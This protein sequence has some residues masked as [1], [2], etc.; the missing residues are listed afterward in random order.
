MLSF[1]KHRLMGILVFLAV[2]GAE[3]KANFTVQC[4]AF[5]VLREESIGQRQDQ[6]R[7][8][9]KKQTQFSGGVNWRKYLFERRL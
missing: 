3:N 6:E 4:S 8:E 1:C 7:G 2:F 9:L 5:R